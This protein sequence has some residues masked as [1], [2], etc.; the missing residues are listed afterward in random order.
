M[1]VRLNSEI[2]CVKP[3]CGNKFVYLEITTL[4]RI[5][6]KVNNFFDRKLAAGG[7]ISYN[8]YVFAKM[9]QTLIIS[10]I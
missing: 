4:Q 2:I 1:Y 7:Q 3:V 10:I 8:I 9:L 6:R 5:W